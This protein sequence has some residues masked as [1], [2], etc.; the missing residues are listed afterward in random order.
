[1]TTYAV[2]IKHN[3]KLHDVMLDPS[4]PARAFKESVYAVTGVPV[5]R[6]KVMVKG[7]ML[8]DGTDMASLSPKNG[9]TFMVLGTAGPLPEAPKEKVTFLEDMSDKDLALAQKQKV[10]LINLGNTCYLN[11]TLQVLRA[12]PEL[13]TALQQ[14]SGRLGSSNGEANLTAALRDLYKS[15]TESSEPFPPLAFLSVRLRLSP[16]PPLSPAD[17]ICSS[18]CGRLRHN[19]RSASPPP[20]AAATRSKTPRRPGCALSMHWGHRCHR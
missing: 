2:K 5:D 16:P 6:Q 17:P 3:G 10:G 14:Y 1:M 12:V 18:Y 9:Q 4:Q 20:K 15:M 19:L 11:S 7:G 13:Q 8:K